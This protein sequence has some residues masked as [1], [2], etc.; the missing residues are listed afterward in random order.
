MKCDIFLLILFNQINFSPSKINTTCETHT[1]KFTPCNFQTFIATK[2]AEWLEPSIPA[3]Q[4]YPLGWYLWECLARPM[5]CKI[6]P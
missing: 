5:R 2:L 1:A 4:L 6:N 3:L